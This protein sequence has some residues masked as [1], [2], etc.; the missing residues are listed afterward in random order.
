MKE[1]NIAQ[2]LV[3]KR[4][5][6]EITQ[7]ALAAYI[8]VS[9]ASVSKWETGQS[10][11]DVTFLPQL[12]AY[13]N[14]TIDELMDYRPQMYKEDIRKLYL[15]LSSD[16][17]SRPFDSV[18][19]ECRQIIKKYFSCFPL[20]LQMGILIVNHSMLASNKDQALLLL[21]EVNEL[22]QRIKQES[23][24]VETV[25]VALYME[26]LCHI[27]LGEPQKAL[28]LLQ[29][30][31]SPKY[32][33]EVLLASAYQMTGQVEEAKR[34]LQVGIYQNIV[35]LFNFFPSYLSLCLD[36]PQRYEQ[37]LQRA[38]A[39]AE[40][41]DLRHLHPVL[42]VGLQLTGAQ[43]YMAQEKPDKALDLLQ[44]YTDTVTSHI[45]PLHLHGD[46]FFD[47]LG[48][49]LSE[50][51][52]GSEMPRNEKTVRQSITDMVIK[53]PAF[54]PLTNERSFQRLTQKLLDYCEKNNV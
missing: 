28:E 42:L 30:S 52:L 37:I 54:S 27:S 29:G 31:D 15:R 21:R 45:Y 41:F 18:I 17:A 1:I 44:D 2:V 51:D 46:D 48:P 8:G 39:V 43:G 25:K 32:P 53:N 24:E 35:V 5:E 4:K 26:A 47:L 12:A 16:F 13:F 10:Y 49:W 9:K 19:D 23:D 34:T 50:L 40:A 3:N 11:P 14:I 36:N 38:F 33:P 22:F 7:D 20:L 6:K